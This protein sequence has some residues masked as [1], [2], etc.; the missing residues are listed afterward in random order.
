[1]SDHAR[2]KE[3]PLADLLRVEAERPTQD[4]EWTPEQIADERAAF[5][6]WVDKRSLPADVRAILLPWK[7]GEA[8]RSAPEP[9]TLQE[10]TK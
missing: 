5:E 2:E 4:E 8:G 10:R 1:M 7:A 9:P 3:Q 6:A